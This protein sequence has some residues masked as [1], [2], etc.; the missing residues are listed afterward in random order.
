MLKCYIMKLLVVIMY[1]KFGKEVIYIGQFVYSVGHWVC[2]FGGQGIVRNQSAVSISGRGMLTTGDIPMPS[3]GICTVHDNIPCSPVFTGWVNVCGNIFSSSKPVLLSD[4]FFMCGSG[5]GKCTLVPQVCKVQNTFVPASGANLSGNDSKVGNNAQSGQYSE[6]SAEKNTVT[7]NTSDNTPDNISEK[8]ITKDSSASLKD[9]PSPSEMAEQH[10]CSGKCPEEY[11]QSCKF[12]ETPSD[13]LCNPNNSNILKNNILNNFGEYYNRTVD[14][15]ESLNKY[16]MD[17]GYKINVSAAHHHII[18]GNQCYG[19]RKF[20]VKLGNFFGYDINCA[21]NGILLPTIKNSGDLIDEEKIR[22]LYSIMK[23]LQNL[24]EMASLR[25]ISGIQI[26]LGPH[27]YK[28]QIKNLKKDYPLLPNPVN[29][30]DAVNMQLDYIVQG[31]KSISRTNCFMRNEENQKRA[32][33][34]KM[35]HVSDKLRKM[36]INFPS[37]RP[38]SVRNRAYVSF[39]ALLYDTVPDFEEFRKYYLM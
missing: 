4:S 15:F 18:P 37:K 24:P 13:V 21:E 29:Y 5:G 35:N 20:L 31:Y 30:E 25:R 3:G 22:V 17:D 9:V 16:I 32:F 26:H 14:I 8:N 7:A 27:T 34:Q 2:P 12:R 39:A 36:I 10:F 1:I 11:C 28:T 33:I 19:T 23:D 38:L 6:S